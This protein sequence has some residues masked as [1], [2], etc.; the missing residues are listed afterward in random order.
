[1]TTTVPKVAADIESLCSKC[2]DVWHVVVAMEKTKVVKVQCK[3]CGGQHRYKPLKAEERGTI[4]PTN[5]RTEVDAEGNIVPVAKVA[6]PKTS[7]AK[8]ATGG[9]SKMLA[10]A[11]MVQADTSKPA[12]T[13]KP[14]EPFAVG[15]RI[16]HPTFGLG[17]VELVPAAGK[18]Q[19]FF[20]SG[21]KLLV[22]GNTV[23]PATMFGA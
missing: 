2:G 3:Q 9:A 12:R 8:S 4:G 6:K 17:V 18:I 7:R 22:S 20:P 19:V 23:T 13:Y 11:P 14:R 16:E 10:N 1:M 21:R 5:R 15:E